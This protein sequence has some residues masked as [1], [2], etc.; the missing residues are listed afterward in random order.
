MF[1]DC[2]DGKF[3]SRCRKI[4]ETEGSVTRLRFA[5]GRQTSTTNVRADQRRANQEVIVCQVTHISVLVCSGS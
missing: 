5:V 3:V 1:F 2:F 4:Y